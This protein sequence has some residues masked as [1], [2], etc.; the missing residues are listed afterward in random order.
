MLFL[1][2][3]KAQGTLA[4]I[5]HQG[6]LPLSKNYAQFGI[7]CYGLWFTIQRKGTSHLCIALQLCN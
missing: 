2:V 7:V 6:K 1:I 3:A 4:I 5:L